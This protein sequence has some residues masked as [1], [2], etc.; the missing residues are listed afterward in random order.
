MLDFASMQ[1][2]SGTLAPNCS[3]AI[4]LPNGI[5]MVNALVE[6]GFTHSYWVCLDLHPH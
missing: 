3:I 5:V 6:K 1:A 2:S 4:L